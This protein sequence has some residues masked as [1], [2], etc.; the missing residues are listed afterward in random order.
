MNAFESRINLNMTS[1]L[2]SA[3]ALSESFESN[4]SAES[5][6]IVWKGYKHVYNYVRPTNNSKFCLSSRYEVTHPSA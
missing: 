2:L 5:S 3:K 4:I 1:D 6:F